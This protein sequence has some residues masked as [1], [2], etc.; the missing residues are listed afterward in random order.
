MKSL[1]PS[2]RPASASAALAP[3]IA[4]LVTGC[5][6]PDD[7]ATAGTATG[8]APAPEV[9]V[10]EIE[11]QSLI[12]ETELAGRTNPYLI[13]EV[14]PQVGGIIRERL[15]EEGSEI[16]AGQVLYRIDPATYQAAYDSARATLARDEAGLLT[17]RL[18]ADRYAK[19]I[20]TGVVSREDFDNAAA[21]LKQAEATVA[22]DRAAVEAARIDLDYTRVT[23]PIAGTIGRSTVT[24]GALVTADQTAALATIQQLDPIYVD[25]TQS[26]VELL[27][28][29][30]ALASGRL[31][32]TNG[33]DA[34]VELILE[35][36][37][38]Y[39]I[40]GRLQFSEVSVDERT[41]TVTLRAV[42][43]NPDHEL[44]PGMYVRA[45]LREGVR[46]AAILA[47]QQ[48]VTR[49]AQGNAT[50]LVLNARGQVETHNVTVERAVGNQWLVTSGLAAGDRLIVDGLQK[51]RPGQDAQP[52]F[53]KLASKSDPIPAGGGH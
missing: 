23:A 37:S 42:F 2:S 32:R 16:E 29:K 51:V 20:E 19:L 50:A 41:G 39:G 9:G 6:H 28:L 4:L 43:P 21:A 47:P 52:V 26:S 35:D 40:T 11:P 17:A 5:G 31:Q 14:R 46:Q 13:A 7:A 8:G 49:D 33:Q 3:L 36:G 53:L 45:V 18:K 34:D 1:R 15:F 48:A 27:H 38:H 10:V 25:V 12:I 24:Q 22:M 30:R 44:L